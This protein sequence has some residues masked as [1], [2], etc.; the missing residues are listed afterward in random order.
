MSGTKKKRGKLVGLLAYGIGALL[1]AGA[2]A[3]GGVYVAQAG[4]LQPHGDPAPAEV[5]YFAFQQPFTSNLRDTGSFAQLSLSVATRDEHSAEAVKVNEAA[6]RSV[7][8]MIV[9]DQD[10]SNLATTAGKQQL[11]KKLRAVM[12]QVLKS[13]TGH[14]G[15]DSVYF[16]SFVIQ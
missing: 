16:T 12:D 7:V 11:Q 2:G 10:A 1:M 8:L 9:A 14:T 5:A 15:I 13:K 3:A 6:L 4:M